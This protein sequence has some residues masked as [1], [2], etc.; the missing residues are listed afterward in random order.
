MRGLSIST[1]WE[2]TKIILARDGR[3]LTTVALALVALP[4]IVEAV[5][6]PAPNLSG[7]QAPSW[8]PVLSI[9]VALLGL[10]GQIAIIRLALGPTTSVGQAISHGLR[11]F[12]PG[13]G[14]ILLFGI[15]L[16]LV[17]ALLFG[18]LAGPTAMEGLR[19]GNMDA[20]AG[21]V[22]L[23]LAILILLVSARFQLIIPVTTAEAGGPIQILR[24]AWDL[25]SGHYLRLLGFLM[26]IIVTALIVLLAAQF[27]GGIIGQL[28]FGDAKPLSLAALVIAL[29]SGLV[30]T[31]FV[32]VVSTL[33]ARIYAQVAGSGTQPSVPISGI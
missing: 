1:A 11:R 3:L 8:T 4:E 30:Q 33:L 2:E 22:L 10:I 12:L 17:L 13:L 5:L 16:I 19:T 31:A 26:A 21:R 6:V 24:R 15:P 23:L 25:A 18:V 28:F 14:A 9:I 27:L 32:V 7:Q 29:I 20:S